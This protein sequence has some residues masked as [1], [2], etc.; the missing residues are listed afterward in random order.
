MAALRR[1]PCCSEPRSALYI[2]S[3]D[4][5]SDLLNC[6]RKPLWDTSSQPHQSSTGTQSYGFIDRPILSHSRAFRYLARLCIPKS[7][8]SITNRLPGRRHQSV[9]SRHCYLMEGITSNSPPSTKAFQHGPYF[10]QT[11]LR[12]FVCEIFR[13]IEQILRCLD[14][15]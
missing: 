5:M 13:T 8:S 11:R 10:S 9:V 3:F 7:L 1:L 12:I 4:H 15:M 2:V 14:K 6:S